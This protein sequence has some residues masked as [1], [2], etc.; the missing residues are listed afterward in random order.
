MSNRAA[1]I[2][3]LVFAAVLFIIVVGSS[4][5][6]NNQVS[7]R[8]AENV[9]ERLMTA[10]EPNVISFELQIK[11][12]IKKVNTM[13]AYFS[14]NGEL[15]DERQINLMRIA[16]RENKLLRCAISDENG[17]FITHDNKTGNAKGMSFYENAMKGKFDISDPQP[18]V[19]DE[20]QTVILFTSP[21]EKEGKIAGTL[22]YSYLCEDIDKIFN[23]DF[24][25]G[26]GH[27]MVIDEEGG[28]LVGTNMSGFNR[29]ENALVSLESSCMHKG[30]AVE[31]CIPAQKQNLDESTFAIETENESKAMLVYCDKLEFNDWYMLALVPVADVNETIFVITDI[32]RNLAIIV[33]ACVLLY[34]LT[35]LLVRVI[36]IRNLDPL[37]KAPRL[38]YF[39]RMA[40]RV[41]KKNKE[42]RFIFVKLDIKDFK[43]INRIYDFKEGDRVIRNMSAALKET[44]KGMEATYARIE[45]DVFVIMLPFVNREKLD[46]RRQYFISSFR[47]FM[48]KDFTTYTSFPTGQYI[49][50]EADAEHTDVSEI[51][52]KANF[53]HSLAKRKHNDIIVDYEHNIEKEALIQKEIED[54][55]GD[56]LKNNSYKLYLQ[57]KMCTASEELCGAEALVR[58]IV[59]GVPI[60]HPAEFV[61]ALERNGFIVKLDMYMFEHAVS[62]IRNQMDKNQR[63]VPISVNFSRHHL[64]N[65]DFVDELVRIADM[66]DV[67][68]EMLEIELTESTVFE[69]VDKILDIIEQLHSK[70]FRVAMDDF[71]SG[72]SSL[73]LLKDIKVD[74]LKIDKGF[75]THESDQERNHVVLSHVFAMARELNTETV[76]EGVEY[77]E[78]V[79]LLRELGCDIIQGYYYGYPMPSDTFQKKYFD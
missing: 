12:Q 58:W 2:F 62:F 73:G 28:V 79:D 3:L 10:V 20:T 17:D 16:V 45:A 13:A 63:P 23:L 35:V 4:M 42:K 22:T 14:E 8:L 25:G 64:N 27:M 43:L 52:E 40:K 24:L 55:M 71:G 57:P 68:T 29:G 48:G 56:A 33:F 9:S 78:Q 18:A 39:K 66:H 74:V 6:L 31:E 32:Q 34:L 49:T 11:E 26:K 37:T 47:Q 67:P 21:I 5:L 50:T 76:A 41:I 46:E 77:K 60:M 65:E 61:P 53:A 38:E 51:L 30:H 70:G 15:G 1:N 72:Y 36:V 19:V 59:G 7:M 69:N 54:K 75:F 44:L